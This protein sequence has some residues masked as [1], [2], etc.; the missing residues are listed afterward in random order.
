MWLA[1]AL[2]NSLQLKIYV[3]HL[4]AIYLSLVGDDQEQFMIALSSTPSRHI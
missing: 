2:S 1:T 4:K 3:F